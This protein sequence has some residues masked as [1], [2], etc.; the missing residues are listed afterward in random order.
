MPAPFGDRRIELPDPDAAPTSETAAFC[1][2]ENW[3]RL[4]WVVAQS[5]DGTFQV[6]EDAWNRA[7]SASQAGL[8]SWMS[9]CHQN[10]GPVEIVGASTRAL[11]A[12]YDTRSGLRPQARITR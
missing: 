11:L 5:D 8:A 10:G 9:I 2:A 4:D 3:G 1:D 12:T 6:D 7:L